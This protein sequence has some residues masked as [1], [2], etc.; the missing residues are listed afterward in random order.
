MKVAVP[1]VHSAL[2]SRWLRSG[3]PVCDEHLIAG[4]NQWDIH[5]AM[6]SIRAT[7]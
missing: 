7:S 1:T 5:V 3:F 4:F 2:L 6:A